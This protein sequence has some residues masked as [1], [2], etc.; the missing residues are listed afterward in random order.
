VDNRV[1]K[2]LAMGL[3][4][5]PVFG[6]RAPTPIVIENAVEVPHKPGV[7]IVNACTVNLSSGGNPKGVQSVING[8]GEPNTNG[9]GQSPNY[10]TLFEDG[11]SSDESR[12]PVAPADE[13]HW[14]EALNIDGNGFVTTNP[15]G[16]RR[17]VAGVN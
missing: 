15:K 12:T 7:K 5:Y 14:V 11:V 2:H 4:V 13:E 9:Y 8:T 16:G 3:G 6:G 1:N 10:V 17:S